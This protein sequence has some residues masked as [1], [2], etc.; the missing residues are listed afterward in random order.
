MA[1][2][3]RRCSLARKEPRHRRKQYE[4]ENPMF[5]FYMQTARQYSRQGEIALQLGVKLW[6]QERARHFYIKASE[7]LHGVRLPVLMPA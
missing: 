7:C 3:F 6:A 4:E 2:F 5:A 1:A